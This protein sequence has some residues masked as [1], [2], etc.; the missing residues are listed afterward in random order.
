M[1]NLNFAKALKCTRAKYQSAQKHLPSTY[2][3]VVYTF[4]ARRQEI[5]RNSCFWAVKTDVPVKIS[6]CLRIIILDKNQKCLVE[7]KESKS[8]TIIFWGS[9]RMRERKNEEDNCPKHNCSVGWDR[10]VREGRIHLWY[11][12]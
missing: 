9:L 4:L 7:L 6:S 11:S 5:L 1:P 3:T 10:Q 12:H 8:K 2:S